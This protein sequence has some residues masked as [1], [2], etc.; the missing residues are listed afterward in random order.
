MICDRDWG[1]F[2]TSSM[3]IL[4]LLVGMP[5]AEHVV[6]HMELRGRAVAKVDSSSRLC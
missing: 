2:D 3:L 1:L 5:F 6:R 4:R